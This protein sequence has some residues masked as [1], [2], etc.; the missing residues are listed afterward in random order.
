LSAREAAVLGWTAARPLLIATRFGDTTQLHLVERAGGARRQ[1]TFEPEPVSTGAFSPDPARSGLFFLEDAGGD[2][3]FQL[4][5]RRLGGA[6]ARILTDGKSANGAAIW[7]NS[8][9]R[10]HFRAPRATASPSTS[11]SSSRKAAR[12]RGSCWRATG[13]LGPRSIGRPTTANCSR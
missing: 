3:K 7:S 9:V 10:S 13:P 2:E 12:C 1:L 8:G 6:A 4:F 11:M 5:Y